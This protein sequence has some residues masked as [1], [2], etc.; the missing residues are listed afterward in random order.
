MEWNYSFAYITQTIPWFLK[1]SYP[2]NIIDE[3]REKSEILENCSKRPKV[4]KGVTYH[5]SLNCLSNTIDQI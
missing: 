2:E 3:E 1:R 5:P 4:S